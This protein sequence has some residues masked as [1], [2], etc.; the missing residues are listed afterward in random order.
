M[1]KPPVRN[2]RPYVRTFSGFARSVAKLFVVADGRA[3]SSSI[4]RES[5][6]RR[7]KSEKKRNRK[8]NI[9]SYIGGNRFS[10]LSAHVYGGG[11]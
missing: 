5:R 11:G 6:K 1:K 10:T 9:I 7:D 4:I 8:N 2:R 3:W